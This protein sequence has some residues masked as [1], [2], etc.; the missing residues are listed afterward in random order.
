MKRVNKLSLPMDM[1]EGVSMTTPVLT[2]E[3]DYGV[4]ISDSLRSQIMDL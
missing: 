2:P 3:L 4:M 1:R